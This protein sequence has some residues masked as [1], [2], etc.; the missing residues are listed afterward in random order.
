[1]PNSIMLDQQGP[2]WPLGLIL[3]PTPGTPVG[4]MSLVDPSSV[5]A[6]N[7]SLQPTQNPIV[8]GGQQEYTALAQQIMFQGFK[9]G[10]SHGYQ[11]NAG[12]VYIVRYPSRTVGSGNRDDQG[13]IVGVILPAQTIFISSAP[14][15][16]NT[17]S[18]YRYYL[19]ADSASDGAI[20]TLFIQ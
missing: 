6:P 16:R 20:V 13:V 2:D 12:N 18:P 14:R 1:M 7:T 15:N 9:A 4:I 17:F 8:T 10:G 19:D 3:V 11:P 5:N